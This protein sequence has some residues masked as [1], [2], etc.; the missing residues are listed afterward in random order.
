VT[1]RAPSDEERGV[2]EQPATTKSNGASTTTP[3]LTLADKDNV[4]LSLQG[5]ERPCDITCLIPSQ[6]LGSLRVAVRAPVIAIALLTPIAGRAQ[7]P[8]IGPAARAQDLLSR[9]KSGQEHDVACA[10]LDEHVGK[11]L[12]ELSE[13]ARAESLERMAVALRLA[14][15]AGRC[16]ASEPL[17]GSA[18]NGLSD[19]LLG[20]GAFDRA[21]AVAEESIEIHGR[22]HDD[23]GL[24]EAWNR[25]GNAQW[26]RNNA[27]PALDAFHRALD[28][29]SGAQDHLGQARAWNNLAQV[30]KGL[31][32]LETA[33]D[34]LTRALR[35]FEDL[36]DWRRA[37]VVT[38]NIAIVYFQRGEY[39]TA[40]EYNGRALE[41]NRRTG[42]RV[43]ASF[44][45][46][47][48]IYRALGAY[49]RALESFQ[50]AL[51]IRSSSGDRAGVMETTHNIGLVHFS[52]GDYQLAIDAYKHGLRLNHDLHDQ[53]FAAEALRNIGAAAWRLGQHERAG[54]NVRGS[55]AIARREHARIIEGDL[56]HDLGQMALAEERLAEAS[57]LFD[58]ALD[59]RRGVGDQAGITETLTALAAARLAQHRYEAALDLGERARANALAHDQ[60]EL[61][62]PAQTVVGVAYRRLHRLEDARR[63]LGAAIGSIEQLSTRVSGSENLRQRFF[64][65]K[66][67]PYHELIELS[68][69]ERAF[70]QALELAERSK[71]RVLTQLLR[72]N[73]VDDS[74]ILTVEERR[75]RSRLRDAVSV[76]NTRIE[77]EQGKPTPDQSRVNA[78]ESSRRAAREE[79][80]AFEATVA[81][82]H[83]E[84]AAVRGEV[85]PLT[86]ADAGAMLTDRTTAVIEYVLA[87]RQLFAF[88][89]T[90]DGTR[91]SVDGHAID[92]GASELA[93]RAERFRVQIGS[94]DLAFADDAR[95]LYALLLAPFRNRL[96]R[97]THLIVVPDGAL[98]SVPF[99]ALIGPEGYLIETAAVSYA[100]SLA[101]LREIRRLPRPA[102]IR[103]LLAMGKAQFG[104]ARSALGPLPDAEIQVRLIRDIYGPD[105]SVSYVGDEAT[106]SQFKIAA[107]RYSVLHL[108]THGVLDEASPLYSYLALSSDHTPA[109]DDGRLEAW[110]IMRLKLTADLVVLAACDTGRGRIARGEGVIGTM[111]ALFAAG[112]RSMAVSQFSV[113]SKSTTALLVAFHRHLAAERGSKAGQL[114]AAAIELLRTPRYAHPY[115]W[116]GFILVGDSD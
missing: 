81:A 10:D 28:L 42:N 43:A 11:V 105:R 71:A 33:L 96:V 37:A 79:L 13:Q 84:L 69:E 20:Q 60:P 114:R 109:D 77:S 74:T 15:R 65:D 116:A 57:R 35:V 7:T 111:W 52:Q 75:G 85:S 64:E 50:Q 46:A 54:A 107:P 88:L 18:L 100:P 78:L 108:A 47:G 99:Q 55:L 5:V 110:E 80:A 106:E 115:Y 73:R 53:A 49:Q 89:V 16:A 27:Q 2:P 51:T 3:R 72:G 41:M 30:H 17:V 101:V 21:L 112:A 58:E 61:L 62:W 45:S 93:K 56:V 103:T 1:A 102:G 63:A 48:N 38:N 76:L 4:S 97:R 29:S 67:S 6:I 95:A 70:G 44:D 92:V 34:Y 36:G 22:L 98:W 104:P 83:P 86:L 90:S 39:A 91:V 40:L 24:A 94:R 66:L 19:V 82:G 31:G 25:V 23:A 26:W 113:E 68:I 32:E 12:I 8:A 14:E 59:I 87:D 9:T